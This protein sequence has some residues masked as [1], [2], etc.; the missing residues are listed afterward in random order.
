M[1]I[2]TVR[3]LLPLLC[4]TQ[5]IIECVSNLLV[6]LPSERFLLK[7]GNQI[8]NKVY[9]KLL[10]R[11]LE[12][13]LYSWRDRV[14][15]IINAMRDPTADIIWILPIFL[16]AQGDYTYDYRLI[17]ESKNKL[18]QQLTENAPAKIIIH[19]PDDPL[20]ELF[21]NMD[22]YTA[23]SIISTDL[24]NKL[25]TCSTFMNW[26]R[27][28][29]LLID[30]KGRRSTGNVKKR[31]KEYEARIKALEEEMRKQKKVRNSLIKSINDATREIDEFEKKI[32][33]LS[34]ILE[35]IAD[36]SVHSDN[37]KEVQQELKKKRKE[38][39]IVRAQKS[40][41]VIALEKLLK[42][43][44]Q[45]QAKIASIQDSLESCQKKI[46][47]MAETEK[48][49]IYEDSHFS[50]AGFM[51]G[52]S[53]FT[54]NAVE[55]MKIGKRLPA[56]RELVKRI[57]CARI[58]TNTANLLVS[59]F[60]DKEDEMIRTLNL[61][62]TMKLTQEGIRDILHI[63]K[64]ND[65]IFKITIGHH[66]PDVAYEDLQLLIQNQNNLTTIDLTNAGISDIIATAIA[67]AIIN[68]KD[69]LI[70]N[71]I[72]LRNNIGSD[73]GR[74]FGRM[75]KVNRTLYTLDLRSNRL[76]D[77]GVISLCEGLQGNDCLHSLRLENNRF[78]QA[79][80]IAYVNAMI[81]P[82]CQISSL[83]VSYNPLGMLGIEALAPLLK[84]PIISGR[85]LSDTDNTLKLIKCEI[86]DSTMNIL[87]KLLADI[88]IKMRMSLNLKGNKLTAKGFN[89]LGKCMRGKL[90]EID[91]LNIIGNSLAGDDID[92][93]ADGI[94]SM[95]ES[96][97]G[98]RMSWC[99]ITDTI[100]YKLIPAV[101]I[102]KLDELHLGGNPFGEKGLLVLCEILSQDNFAVKSLDNFGIERSTVIDCLSYAKNCVKVLN[103][104]WIFSNSACDITPLVQLIQLDG[105]SNLTDLHLV[106]NQLQDKNVKPLAK[107]LHLMPVLRYVGLDYNNITIDGVLYLLTAIESTKFRHLRTINLFKNQ[108]NKENALTIIEKFHDQL[109]L[110]EIIANAEYRIT[111]PFDKS[112]DTKTSDD[113][114]ISSIKGFVKCSHLFN[115]EGNQKIQESKI[116]DLKGCELTNDAIDF[117]TD[118][119]KNLSQGLHSLNL[120]EN[121][122]GASG[123][124]R[125]V[126]HFVRDH[127]QLENL[128][129]L[130]I[131]HNV[132]GNKAM[133][134]I[135][136][137]L[138]H[139]SCRLRELDIRDTKIT[140]GG[141]K[142]IINNIKNLHQLRWGGNLISQEEAKS[143]FKN[144]SPQE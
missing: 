23:I 89:I 57:S 16:Y 106:E 70:R 105:F 123:I 122:L 81:D 110:L 93:F 25:L 65:K 87:P 76:G 39:E 133:K 55:K 61:P 121:C 49:D 43:Y 97:G 129:Y 91:K 54:D 15:D 116:C 4:D 34:E 58:D 141:L 117:I 92:Q 45:Q 114:F 63:I 29:K 21:Q 50:G 8:I 9:L 111:Q 140:I 144:F 134:Y 101:A 73:G 86:D 75:L 72:L 113:Q 79:G 20:K 100:L 22:R 28:E 10:R 99:D 124:R 104:S 60:V 11:Y 46:E 96:L 30:A 3:I 94:A 142:L 18:L 64:D 51:K 13:S 27:L 24:A 5:I 59:A 2:Q 115:G 109:Y 42:L 37:V 68:N 119:L 136:I 62:A 98:I 7:I 19:H 139:E 74:E 90:M 112:D 102:A 108:L 17:T 44:R 53:E 103:L 41:K 40:D 66:I 135:K 48:K 12:S 88:K 56:K 130:N 38:I 47:E 132:L 6:N 107:V 95:G 85:I 1:T 26:S 77:Q 84:S 35:S 125:L 127:G 143:L 52:S 118:R 71:L 32:F 82:D 126:D 128:Q 67:E 138:E 36:N 69:L 120:S 31:I 78:S 14:D 131:S 33:Q 83:N 80:I 137:L